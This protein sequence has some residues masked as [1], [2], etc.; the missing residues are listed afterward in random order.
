MESSTRSGAY[1]WVMRRFGVVGDVVDV[2]YR[3]D[4][5]A[6]LGDLLAEEAGGFKRTAVIDDLC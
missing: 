2:V 3:A 1:W 4:C 6:E 5:L